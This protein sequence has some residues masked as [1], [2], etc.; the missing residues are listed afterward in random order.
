MPSRIL[1]VDNYDSFVYTIVG[2]LERLGA[3]V[4]VV[5]NDAIAGTEADLDGFDGVLVS[6]GPGTP[7]QAGASMPIIE[8]CA[9]TGTP[10]LGVCLGHQALAEA[11]GATVTHAPELM[12]GKT[13]LVAHHGDGVLAGL[14]EPFTATRYHSLAVVPGTVPAELA[15]TAWVAGRDDDASAEPIVMGLAHRE[16]PLHGVQFHPESVLTEGGYRILANWL[17]VTGDG[18]AVARSEGMAPLAAL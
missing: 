15:V 12:H 6:P 13:S 1:V 5:R 3:D 14:G 8:A 4:V 10:M 18:D 7:A 9:R 2:Y 16:L 17:A 11:F